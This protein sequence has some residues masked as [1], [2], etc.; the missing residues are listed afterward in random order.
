[1][2]Q[3]TAVSIAAYVTTGSDLDKA[4]KRLTKHGI[5]QENLLKHMLEKFYSD[6]PSAV[7][8]SYRQVVDILLCF[9]LIA[10]ISQWK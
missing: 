6:C 10:R 2:K 9:H 4:W 1:M 7:L 8:I 3:K 5:L